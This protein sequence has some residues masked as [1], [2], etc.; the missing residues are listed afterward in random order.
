VK[1]VTDV[2]ILRA[3]DTL[4]GDVKALRLS[5]AD[6][7]RRIIAAVDR[8]QGEIEKLIEKLTD[9]LKESQE[10]LAKVINENKPK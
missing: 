6:A 7:E 1:H 9:K 4:R 5:L 3:L 8:K 2:E 10:R